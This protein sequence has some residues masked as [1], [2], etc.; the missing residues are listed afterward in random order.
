VKQEKILLIDDEKVILEVVGDDLKEAGFGVVQANNGAEGL[1]QFKAG[2]FDLVISDLMMDETDGF[3]V[4]RGIK[5]ISPETPVIIITGYP[6]S[7]AAKEALIL[8][9]S[10]VIIKPTGMEE[11]FKVIRRH[12]RLSKN[13]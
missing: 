3:G 10:D 8:G 5:R 4:L 12:M 9:A 13:G 11:I 6:S 1:L 2:E 7:K